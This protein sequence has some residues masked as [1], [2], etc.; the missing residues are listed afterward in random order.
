M[1]YALSGLEDEDVVALLTSTA[2]HELQPAGIALAHLIYAETD[3][4]PLFAGEVLRHLA[5]TGAVVQRDGMWVTVGEVEDIGIPEGVRE[6]IGRRLNRLSDE[7][8]KVLELA[9]VIGRSFELPVLARLTETEPDE[10][11]ELLDPAVDA[12]IVREVGVGDYVFADALF[13]SALYDEVRPTRRARLHRRVAEAIS[14]VYPVDPDPHLG[15]LAYH[16]AHSVGSGDAVK[17][18]EYACRRAGNAG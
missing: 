11:A 18:I 16:Y 1:R 6:V 15:E 14:A 7:T 2:G 8:N 13:R 17:A 4:N 12:R 5:E 10:L 9:A 3:G